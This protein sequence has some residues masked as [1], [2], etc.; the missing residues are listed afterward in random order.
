MQS[1]STRLDLAIFSASAGVVWIEHYQ[2][3][4]KAAARQG[5]TE[6]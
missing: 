5:E 3:K 6:R 2:I 1:Y 4:L